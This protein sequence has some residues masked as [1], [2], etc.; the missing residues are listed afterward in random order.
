[1]IKW[2]K[3]LVSAQAVKTINEKYKID[4]L[5]STILARRNIL[6]S[7]E[8][9]YFAEK[10]I[11][12][13]HS[14]FEFEDMEIFCDR[15]LEAVENKEKVCVFGDRDVDGITSTTLLVEELR[16]LGLETVYSLPQGDD[17]YGLTIAGLDKIKKKI[18]LLQLL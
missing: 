3:N 14:P 15:I 11:S 17:P 18:S 6:K 16:R 1:M 8:I 10:D 7:D 4:L 12:F 9:K 5:K 13:L 2:Q